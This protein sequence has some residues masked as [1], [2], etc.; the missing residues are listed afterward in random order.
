MAKRTELVQLALTK[1]EKQ[2]LQTAADALAIPLA[3]W[4]RSHAL[5]EASHITLR[6][7]GAA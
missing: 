6:I 7:K 2:K 4:V 5:T 1:E 3:S